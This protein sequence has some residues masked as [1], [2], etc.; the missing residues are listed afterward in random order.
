M[1]NGV[2]VNPHDAILFPLSALQVFAIVKFKNLGGKS[3]HEIYFDLHITI[4]WDY[5]SDD[6]LGHWALCEKVTIAKW[7]NNQFISDNQLIN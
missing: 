7:H 6:T 1:T 2:I 3:N 4:H 5:W